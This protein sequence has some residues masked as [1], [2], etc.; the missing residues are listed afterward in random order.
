MPRTIF[1]GANWKMHS[2]PEGACAK[3]CPF[4]STAN[5]H[6]TVFPT[7]FDLAMCKNADLSIG[8]QHARAEKSGAFT[9]DISIEM[10]KEHGCEYVLC[11]HSEQRKYH[12][13]KDHAIWQQVNAALD[14]GITPILC[15]GE[16]QEEHKNNTTK[17]VLRRQIPNELQEGTIIAYEPCW[18]IGNGKT[19]SCDDIQNAHAYIRG[20]IG[21]NHRIL[22]GGS[23]NAENAEKI[24]TLPNVDGLLIGNASLDPKVFQKI[25][26]IAEKAAV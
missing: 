20:I 16:T 14:N 23:V 25:A 12:G 4:R 26:E 21:T 2:V 19:A 24:L 7:L 15:I 11:G 1:L 17:D 10:L 22:Y 6:I 18:A 13:E 9:G 8:A 5:V 3:E